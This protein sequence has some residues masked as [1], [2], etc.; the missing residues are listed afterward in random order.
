MARDI[1]EKVCHVALDFQVESEAKTQTSYE[2]PDGQQVIVNNQDRLLC[3]EALFR[4]YL[5]DKDVEGL[6]DMV[7]RSIIK[8]D[9]TVR[10][11]LYSNVVLAGGSSLFPGFPE[12]F[13]NELKSLAPPKAKIKILAKPER[14]YSA[15]LG[16]SI[17]ASRPTFQ[18]MWISRK[19]YEEMGSSV[20]HRK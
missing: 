4:P 11:Q 13:E 20:F 12:R 17:V 2:L 10:A 14:R 19:E 1:K 6:P 18:S 9:V 3:T 7:Y 15:W 5:M 16:G 8:F